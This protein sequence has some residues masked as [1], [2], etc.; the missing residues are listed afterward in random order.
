MEKNK[1]MKEVPSKLSGAAKSG[2]KSRLVVE[3]WLME[4]SAIT[5]QAKA[6]EEG[7]VVAV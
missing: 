3:G 1:S 2:I 5:E 6:E 4:S 7:A